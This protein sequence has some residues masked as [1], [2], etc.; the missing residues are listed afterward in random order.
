MTSLYRLVG[1]ALAL[2][3][4]AGLLFITYALYA[5]I[6]LTLLVQL[7]MPSVLIGT[8]AGA[9]L[10]GFGVWLAGFSHPLHG[11]AARA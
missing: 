4:L 8:L 5:R 3:G 7:G 1:V 9:A 11:P 2:A 10:V 6:G